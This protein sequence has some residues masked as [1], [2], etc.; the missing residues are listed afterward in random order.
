[1][2]IQTDTGKAG[3]EYELSSLTRRAQQDESRMIFP[4]RQ[5]PEPLLLMA[6]GKDVTPDAVRANIKQRQLDK[7]IPTKNGISTEFGMDA[8]SVNAKAFKSNGQVVDLRV[9]ECKIGLADCGVLGPSIARQLKTLC[10]TGPDKLPPLELISPFMPTPQVYDSF[11]LL[12]KGA[13]RYTKVQV[14][15]AANVPVAVASGAAGTIKLF[16]WQRAAVRA[17]LNAWNRSNTRLTKLQIPM[18]L[19]KTIAGWALLKNKPDQWSLTKSVRIFAAHTVSIAMQALEEAKLLGINAIDLTNR[20]SNL[21]LPEAAAEDEESDGGDNDEAMFATYDGKESK[22]IIESFLAVKAAATLEKPAYI[23]VCHHTLRILAKT[24]GFLGSKPVALAIDE[25]HLLHKSK[26]VFER[27]FDPAANIRAMAMS[28]T[29][30]T[31]YSAA[32]LGKYLAEKMCDAPTTFRLGLRHGIEM[33]LLVPTHIEIVVGSD[34]K[35]HEQVDDTSRA[36]VATKAKTIASWLAVN[37]LQTC[38]VF[39]KRIREANDLKKLIK[40][41]LEA[42]GATAWCDAHHSGNTS[43]KNREVLDEFKRPID[44][45]TGDVDFKVVVSVGQ[46]REGFNFPSLQAVVITNPREDELQALGRVMRAFPGKT[47]GRALLFGKD[48]STRSVSRMLYSYDREVRSIT[49]GCVAETF[50]EQ[51]ETMGGKN[52][53]LKERLEGTSKKVAEDAHDCLERMAT[54]VTNPEMLRAIQTDA[55]VEQ[56]ATAAPK[57][58]D[59]VKLVY[60]VDGVHFKNVAYGWWN[61]TK[62]TYWHGFADE[63]KAKLRSLAWWKD[64]APEK[65]KRVPIADRLEDAMRFMQTHNRRPVT[66]NDDEKSLAQ[67]LNN[68]TTNTKQTAACIKAVGETRHNDLLEVLNALPSLNLKGLREVVAFSVVNK[69]CPKRSESGGAALSTIRTGQIDH[70]KKDEAKSIVEEALAGNEFV[71]ARNFL[72]NSIELS[73]KNN[74]EFIRKIREKHAKRKKAEPAAAA[75]SSSSVASSSAP[76]MP[77]P[78]AKRPRFEMSDDESDDD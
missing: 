2:S 13:F 46:L 16:D 14:D 66:T 1:M 11:S 48:R 8:V 63:C 73:V 32:V 7:N 61:S 76:A 72:L 30:P 60:K 43:T 45:K 52:E 69:R 68:A 9:V 67:W 57:H 25:F 37:R 75:S 15:A 70:K 51:V 41:E 4:A 24:P 33:G 39:V 19:G 6:G 55:F 36:P 12:P 54:V 56:F 21:V 47:M 64:P 10:R 74:H 77:T 35:T 71:E 31:K 59:G 38:S 26:V 50:D 78:P 65:T 62:N 58:S 53:A 49:V 3:R 44:P 34:D 28:G 42:L 23:V 5:A 17:T 27:I 29:P 40:A 18:G 20:Q 22:R